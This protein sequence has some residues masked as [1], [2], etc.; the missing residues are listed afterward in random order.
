MQENNQTPRKNS[1]L[2]EFVRNSSDKDRERVYGVAI[3]SAIEAQQKI[4]QASKRLIDR[5]VL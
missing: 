2:S 1:P 3:K 4:I 5:E